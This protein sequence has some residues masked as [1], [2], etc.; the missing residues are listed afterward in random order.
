MAVVTLKRRRR[1]T[2][3]PPLT[4]VE[5]NPGPK[6]GAKRKTSRQ[7]PCTP[8]KPRKQQ[9]THYSPEEKGEIRALLE[10]GLSAE[11]IIKQGRF[12]KKAVGRVSKEWRSQKDRESQPVPVDKL[13]EPDDSCESEQSEQSEPEQDFK[14]IEK[15]TDFEKGQIIGMYITGTSR[16]QIAKHLGRHKKSVSRW[17][18]RWNEDGNTDRK[19]GSGRPRCTL[20][21]DDRFIKITSLKDR[22]LTAKDIAKIM[23]SIADGQ[24]VT[25]KTVS[26]RLHEFGLY[27][28]RP[29]KKPGL[30]EANV[31]ARLAW[32][33]KHEKWTV[34]QWSQVVWS[35]ESPFT[36]YQGKNPWVRRREGEEHKDI[37]MVP[38]VKHGGGSILVWLLSCFRSWS[39]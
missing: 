13:P 20:A 37:A 22:W 14:G 38:T 10:T 39:A 28:R 35:D 19:E 25:A 8:K 32:A 23:N 16:N 21:V 2:T 17:I 9:R 5:K 1:G 6:T 26:R 27:A 7:N 3:C 12:S 30:S 31:K 15:L 11:A 18:N 34:E 29:R 4:C 33:K 36:L 24:K